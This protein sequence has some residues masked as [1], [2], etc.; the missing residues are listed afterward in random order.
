[1][2][3]EN[4]GDLGASAAASIYPTDILYF[5]DLIVLLLAIKFLRVKKENES[6][7]KFQRSAYFTFSAAMLFLNLGLAEAERPQLLTR[8]FDRE[9][10]VKNLGMY[11]YHLY[12]IYIQSKSQAQRAFADSSE[13]TEVH[14]Y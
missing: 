2:Q 9:M 6:S 8:S 10:L 4:F 11:N 14:N 13:L 3:T 5:T 1:F 7:L 12:D